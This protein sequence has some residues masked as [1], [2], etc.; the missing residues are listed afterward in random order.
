MT[1]RAVV[2]ALAVLTLVGCGDVI[3]IGRLA[4]T[5]RLEASLKPGLSSRDDVMR[6]LGAP[7]SGGAAL[8]PGWDRPQETWF[9]LYEEGSLTEERRCYVYVFFDD[10]KYDGYLWFSS[11]GQP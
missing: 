5:S 6:E 4:D 10:A 2:I 3:R 8:L 11:L 1:T 7:R 9:Y